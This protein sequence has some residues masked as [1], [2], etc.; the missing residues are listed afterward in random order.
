MCHSTFKE[1]SRKCSATSVL[2][3]LLLEKHATFV[4]VRYTNFTY[5]HQNVLN[6][7]RMDM[8]VQNKDCFLVR[9][10]LLNLFA[11]NVFTL[12]NLCGDKPKLLNDNDKSQTKFIY[13]YIFT[14]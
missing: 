8:L 3:Q 10:V 7:H 6:T 11:C 12:E 13:E 9:D 5:P 2:K 4:R 1:N 14:C